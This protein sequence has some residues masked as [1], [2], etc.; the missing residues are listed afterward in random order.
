MCYRAWGNQA[1][2]TFRPSGIGFNALRV[3]G[4]EVGARERER[5]RERV[6]G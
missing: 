2:E 6:R 3:L 1:L 5:E 4:F